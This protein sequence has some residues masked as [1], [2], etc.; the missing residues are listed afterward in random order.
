MFLGRQSLQIGRLFSWKEYIEH[1][2]FEEGYDWLGILKVALDIYNGDLKGYS[3][4]SD[5][6]EVRELE[7]RG[8]MQ[9]LIKTTIQNMIYKFQHRNKGSLS[10]SV[11]NDLDSS[12]HSA[13]PPSEIQADAIAIKV[14]IDFCLNIGIT[15]FLFTDI[16]QLFVQYNLREKFI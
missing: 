1:I 16:F 14:A 13:L 4:V 5:E 3:Q 9:D 6:K 7:Q 15:K 10:G 2:K 8:Y 12:T 11:S